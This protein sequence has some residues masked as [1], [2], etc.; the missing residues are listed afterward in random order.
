MFAEMNPNSE[1]VTMLEKARSVVDQLTAYSA[2]VARQLGLMIAQSR[3]IVDSHK[4]I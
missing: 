4:V 1:T 3:A 2:A